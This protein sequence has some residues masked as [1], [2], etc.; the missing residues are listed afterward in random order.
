MIEFF[1]LVNLAVRQHVA[2]DITI[3][4]KIVSFPWNNKIL[5]ICKISIVKIIDLV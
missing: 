3:V 4:Q 5:I 2:S 1:F